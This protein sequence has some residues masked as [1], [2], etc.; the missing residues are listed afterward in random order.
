MPELV[1]EVVEV[2]ALVGHRAADAD[3]VHA[4]VA[5]AARALFDTLP[6]SAE[7]VARSSGVQ[8][9]PRQKIGTPLTTRPKPLAVGAAVDVDRAEADAPEIDRLVAVATQCE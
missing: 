8:Q 3:H 1:A 7:S 9:T 5:R 6:G 2:V 4:G